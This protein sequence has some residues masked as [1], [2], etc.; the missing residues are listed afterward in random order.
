MMASEQECN[1]DLLHQREWNDVFESVQ[2]VRGGVADT[3]CVCITWMLLRRCLTG[4]MLN[5]P[6]TVQV[7]RSKD[8]LYFASESSLQVIN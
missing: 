6:F 7:D 1:K 8:T 3:A 4:R 2:V 5:V